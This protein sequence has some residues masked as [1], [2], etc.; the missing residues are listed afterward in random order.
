MKDCKLTVTINKPVEEVFA[1][2]IDPKNTPKWVASIVAEQTNEW[3]VKLGTI[4]RNQRQNGEWSEYEITEFKQNKAFVMRQKNDSFHVGYVFTPASND[5]ATML[6]YRVWK[7]EGEGEL[8]ESLTVAV[9]QG[10]L[11]KLKRAV[12]AS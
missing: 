12:E 9:L 1:F 3:P 8:P 2:T 7:D 4:Y 10:I 5:A 6:E 11:D